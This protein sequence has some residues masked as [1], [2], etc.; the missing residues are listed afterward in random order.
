MTNHNIYDSEA[1]EEYIYD[2]ENYSSSFLELES[3]YQNKQK[4]EDIW[5]FA[6]K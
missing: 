6:I 5:W 3:L 4:L 2:S 1:R